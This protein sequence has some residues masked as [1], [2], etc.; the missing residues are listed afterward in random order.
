MHD[1]VLEGTLCRLRAYRSEDAAALASVAND[2]RVARW[3]TRQFPHPYS[4]RD[5]QQWVEFAAGEGRGVHFAIEVKGALAGGIGITLPAGERAGTAILGYWLG[6]AYWGRGI[7]TQAVRLLSAHALR[8]GELRRLEASVFADNLA[9]AKVLE[10]AGFV[11]EALLKAY[12]LDRS[13]EICDGFL[14][15]RIVPGT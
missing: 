13:D 8:D 11:R 12:Y 9:S 4:L 6:H 7:A 14:Y 1:I 2:F 3:M 15:A 5:A 10:K